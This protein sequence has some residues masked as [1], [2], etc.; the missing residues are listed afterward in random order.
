LFELV[1]RIGFSLLVVFGLMWV[2]AKAVRRPLGGRRATGSLS[3]LNRQQLTRGAAL[4][5]VRVGDKALILGVTDQQ[6]SLLGE[7]ELTDFEQPHPDPGHRDP[8]QIDGSI[9]APR[10]WRA[11]V[12]FLRDRTTRR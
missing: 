9:L 1:L 5:V 3:V 10:T 7:A 4:A 11:T 8:V 2:L 6:V 12:T